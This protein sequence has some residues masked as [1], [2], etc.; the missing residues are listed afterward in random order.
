MKVPPRLTV[1]RPH[2]RKPV[3]DE[4]DVFGLTHPGLVRQDNQDHFLTCSLH[5]S[6]KIHQ[7]S[8]PDLD[9]VPSLSER[10]A[11]LAMVA[12]GVGGGF[13]GAEASRTAVEAITLY[14][15]RSMHAYYT[16][17]AT[18][19]ALFV[20]AL[21]EAALQCHAEIVQR[22]NADGN[23][24]MATT[25]TLFLG[26]WPRAYLLQVGDSRFYLLRDGHLQQITSDQTVGQEL[27][28]RGIISRSSP[29]SQRWSHVLASALGGPHTSPVVTGIEEDWGDVNLMCSDG[30]T[31]HVS[32]ERIRERLL[33]M[34][35]AKQV[36]EDLLQDALDAGGRDNI[37]IIVGRS[38]RRDGV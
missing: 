26:V 20:D 38:V 13:G 25:L 6:V 21:S 32:D 4:L 5:K 14:V 9:A 35:S 33:A 34:T 24:G 3:G 11:F 30:L 37:T 2:V 36:C 23:A 16:A 10:L 27:I 18:D 7:T 29:A 8:L 12:D 1:P 15:S 31:R 17:D 22:S 19:D 28:D